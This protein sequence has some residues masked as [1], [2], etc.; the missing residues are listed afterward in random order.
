[1]PFITYIR[2]DFKSATL[3]VIEQ[4]NSIIDE[5]QAEG[6]SL[7]LRQLYYQFVSRAL[8]PNTLRQYKR[9]GG[10]VSDARLAGLIDWD[11][12][13]DRTR[14]LED[15]SW[16]RNPGGIL[17]ASA[18]WY[19]TDRWDDQ[20]YRIEVWYE[21][22]ALAGVFDRV[23]SQ[24]EVDHFACIGYVSQSEVWGAAQ[25]LIGYS[26][27]GQIPLILHFGDHD[28]SGIDM[29]R[30]IVDRLDT[31]GCPLEVQRL[32]LNMDQVEEHNP[33]PNPAKTTD[34]RYE[35]YIIEYGDESWELDALE[36]SV[37]ANLVEEEVLS[38]RDDEKW[39]ARI[40]E[41]ESDCER[42][43]LIAEHWES[44]AGYISDL[45]EAGE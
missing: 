3:A 32:A 29:T 30:D 26:E 37:L 43:R 38:Y 41:D 18:D 19:R 33:P 34:S 17:H 45:E 10:I 7:T 44:V 16:W 23:C 5:Y 42:L 40:E 25:R 12:I 35:G 28:P 31:F 11:C 2:K 15:L 22:K 21:K 24:L 39:E 6:Y 8:I 1:M 13:E 27:R 14:E 9:L 36:P 20:P 4:A